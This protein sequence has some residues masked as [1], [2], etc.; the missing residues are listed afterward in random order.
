MD[1]ALA[2]AITSLCFASTERGLGALVLAY[3]DSAVHCTAEKALSQPIETVEKTIATVA[4]TMAQFFT[5]QECLV[6]LD[7][8]SSID[9]ERR[10]L[11]KAV[12]FRAYSFGQ[13]PDWAAGELLKQFPNA[14]AMYLPLNCGYRSAMSISNLSRFIDVLGASLSYLHVSITH[15]FVANNMYEWLA[16][17]VE[18]QKKD[19][20]I[21]V[22]SDF[23]GTD[24]AF[25]N[26]LIGAR[27]FVRY[28]HKKKF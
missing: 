14:R 17:I 23:A 5:E 2:E 27:R 10:A 6:N 13:G 18:S 1:S 4:D 26:P 7:R 28:S 25:S 8:A 15:V 12:H 20:L 19:G 22:D 9:E 21:I 3:A 16:Q 24:C 11:A